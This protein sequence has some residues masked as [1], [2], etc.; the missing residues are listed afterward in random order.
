MPAAPRFKLPLAGSPTVR[1]KLT[2]LMQYAARGV[3]QN[4][5]VNHR[6][7]LMFVHQTLGDCLT[8]E[9]AARARAKAAVGAAGSTPGDL[10]AMDILALQLLLL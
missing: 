10:T 7:L 6:S 4:L 8:R 3:Q 5:T 9:E 1:N 2:Q